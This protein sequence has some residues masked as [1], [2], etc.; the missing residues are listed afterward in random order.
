MIS[1]GWLSHL[2]DQGDIWVVHSSRAD[3][4]A[5]HDDAALAAPELVGR[6]GAL[7][8][9]LAGVHLQ[10]VDAQRLEEL[11][12]ELGHSCCDEEGHDLQ[13][14][15]KGESFRIFSFTCWSYEVIYFR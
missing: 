6:A 15:Y 12:V 4:R 13:Y 11:A 3:I 10:H 1:R 8:L 5:E 7:R 2:Q 14:A 9:R